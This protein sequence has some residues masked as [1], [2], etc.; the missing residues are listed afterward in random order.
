MGEHVATLIIEPRSLFREALVSL[1]ERHSFHVVC[2]VA[3]TAD[4][5]NSL[6]VADV[7]KLVIL[8]ALPMEEATTA[9]SCIRELWPE[10][11]IVLLFERASSTDYQNWQASEID[12]CIPLSVSPDVLISAFQQV[13]DWGFKILIQNTA[14]RLAAAL[15]SAQPPIELA[16]N[17]GPPGLGKFGFIGRLT[18]R[19]YQL[20][21]EALQALDCR[22]RCVVEAH[23]SLYA[24]PR[25]F[26]VPRR[27]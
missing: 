10:T 27:G 13:L 18:G 7:P 24:K 1:M 8:G 11:K 2:G 25:T 20:S 6:L 16:P 17:L 21:D 26:V 4:I 9:A 14:S 23:C 5:D 12:G 19:V 15:P 3:S 22:S